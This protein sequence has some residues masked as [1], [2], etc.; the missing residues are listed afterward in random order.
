MWT[1]A[2]VLHKVGTF[3]GEE[4]DLSLL[5]L[6]LKGLKRRGCVCFVGCLE[7]NEK[8]SN[9][10]RF[11]NWRSGEWAGKRGDCKQYWAHP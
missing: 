9:E 4:I 1:Q 6:F 2:L 11:G 7:E 3:I 8:G 10:V 5:L